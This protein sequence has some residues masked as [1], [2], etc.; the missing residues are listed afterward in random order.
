MDKIPLGETVTAINHVLCF[1]GSLLPQTCVISMNKAPQ[2]N[3]D[4]QPRTEPAL[5]LH[6]RA[7][8]SVGVT[9]PFQQSEHRK[10]FWRRVDN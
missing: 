4:T 10:Q 8:S 7:A 9:S 3:L 5:E 6:S 1:I 2:T